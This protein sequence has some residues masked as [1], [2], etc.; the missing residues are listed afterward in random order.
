[1]KAIVKNKILSR[2]LAVVLTVLLVLFCF[3]ANA[4]A[5]CSSYSS[6]YLG[7]DTGR[8]SYYGAN[9]SITVAG[10]VYYHSHTSTVMDIHSL[11]EN[12]TNSG[13][14]DFDD[15]TFFFDNGNG[16]NSSS[17][18]HPLMPILEPGE[19]VRLEANAHSILSSTQLVKPA[20]YNSFAFCRMT[21]G[22]YGGVASGW[23][24]EWPYGTT[25][26]NILFNQ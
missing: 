22:Q 7:T 20:N 10:Y 25:N 11:V 6:K 12:I 3:T 8:Y 1:M 2:V 18:T 15:A 13:V 4:S 16:A 9:L 26:W 23:S 19:T 14:I 17:Y 24:C 21:A 5:A